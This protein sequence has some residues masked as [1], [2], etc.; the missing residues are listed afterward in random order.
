M[1]RQT[2]GRSFI[3]M[4]P[5]TAALLMVNVAFFILELILSNKVRMHEPDGGGGLD[6]HF[7]VLMYLGAANLSLI[8][9][10]E[11]WRLVA[12]CFLHGGLLHIAFNG[13]ALSSLGRTCEPM[14]GTARFLTTYTVCGVLGSVASMSWY[15][16]KGVN[17]TSIG[18]SGAVLGL[19]GLLLGYSVRHRDHVIRQQIYT[20]F[21]AML[22][23]WFLY[24]GIDH[25]G[26]IGGAATGFVF[27]L[28]VPNYVSSESTVRWKI[29]FWIS[30]GVIAAGLGMA[31]WTMYRAWQG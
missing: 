25:A 16:F 5:A 23:F 4:F 21:F 27:G 7:E 1:Q 13:L 9:Q 20:W 19:V 31:L 11:I 28:F 30:I 15:Y 12:A 22:I 6:P 14:L 10:G 2:Y 29:P 26:H 18:A 8:L 3:D 24:P 17:G